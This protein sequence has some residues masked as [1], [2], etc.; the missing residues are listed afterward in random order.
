MSLVWLSLSSTHSVRYFRCMTFDLHRLLQECIWVTKQGLG[1]VTCNTND[2]LVIVCVFL[3]VFLTALYFRVTYCP[4]FRACAPFRHVPYVP[5]CPWEGLGNMS[6]VQA[7]SGAIIC[8]IKCINPIV[9]VFSSLGKL[10]NRGWLCT[11]VDVWEVCGHKSLSYQSTMGLV[12]EWT[13][14]R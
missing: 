1:I 2:L 4:I 8:H 5:V 9:V 3:E 7:D 14:Q 6:G 11:G 10:V 12:Q 13:P